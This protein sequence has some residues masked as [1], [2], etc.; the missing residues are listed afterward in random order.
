MKT[1]HFSLSFACSDAR[2]IHCSSCFSNTLLASA[3]YIRD[4]G[5]RTSQRLAHSIT[6]IEALFSVPFL[7]RDGL[8]HFE[9]PRSPF[10]DGG[11][12]RICNTTVYR[13]WARLE[14]KRFF[15]GS[16]SIQDGRNHFFRQSSRPAIDK[17]TPEPPAR[18]I[19]WRRE[20]C[21][22]SV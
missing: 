13:F 20:P 10:P 7:G 1:D 9:R 3:I 11:R 5:L 15:H 14:P 18:G 4:S 12:T 8:L 2:H 21:L 22:T 17:D 16:S 19:G 6:S